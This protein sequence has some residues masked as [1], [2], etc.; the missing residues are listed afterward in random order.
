MIE[1]KIRLLRGLSITLGGFGLMFFWILLLRI[2][3]APFGEYDLPFPKFMSAYS[4]TGGLVLG[5]YL[6]TLT[7]IYKRYLK[8]K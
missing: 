5:N 2:L 7:G 8:E 6:F 4:F 1:K 3:G